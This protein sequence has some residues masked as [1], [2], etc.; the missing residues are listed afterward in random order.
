MN[1]VS[2]AQKNFLL[3]QRKRRRIIRISRICIFLLFLSFLFSFIF[4]FCKNTKVAPKIDVTIYTTAT[5][6]LALK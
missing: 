5:N 4:S 3:S 1:D 2:L 6:N